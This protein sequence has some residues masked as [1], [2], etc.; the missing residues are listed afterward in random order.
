MITDINV[1]DIG[2]D[3]RELRSCR[4]HPLDATVR[5]WYQIRQDSIRDTGSAKNYEHLR[6]QAKSTGPPP[7]DKRGKVKGINIPVTLCVNGQPL[8]CVV[9]FFTESQML[10][11]E[12]RIDWQDVKYK[13]V[14]VSV[15]SLRCIACS[16]T[17]PRFRLDKGCHL[18]SGGL[19]L[20]QAVSHT[21]LPVC[22]AIEY[23]PL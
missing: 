5:T 3:I 19:L 12:R 18:D 17:W 8:F 21:T 4:F 1:V 9:A 15:S 20:C 2:T 23:R 11:T 16:L 6:M 7:W 10:E 14:T 13:H 22:T